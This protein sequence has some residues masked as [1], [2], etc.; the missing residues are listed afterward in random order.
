MW[1]LGGGARVESVGVR[2]PPEIGCVILWGVGLG[3]G[4][5]ESEVHLREGVCYLGVG[6]GWGR[7]DRPSALP[8]CFI[9]IVEMQLEQT[10][11]TCKL[12]E[13]KQNFTPITSGKGSV[14]TYVFSTPVP[15]G[16]Q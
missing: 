2:G 9:I 14:G 16:V 15:G 10:V 12:Q 8:K 5:L 7:K 6:L 11:R 4:Q 3:W 1:Y 13:V